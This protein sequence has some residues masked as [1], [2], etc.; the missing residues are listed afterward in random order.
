M[1]GIKISVLFC[2]LSVGKKIVIHCLFHRD[3][4]VNYC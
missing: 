1:G 2:D 3:I 4:T